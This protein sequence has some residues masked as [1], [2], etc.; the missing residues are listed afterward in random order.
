MKVAAAM[1]P[2]HDTALET[3]AREE[4]G[5]DPGQ[6]GSPWS[7]AISSFIAFTIGALIP[8]LPWFFATGNAEVVASVILG[9]IAAVVVG[10]A[11]AKLTGRSPLWSGARQLAITAGAAAVTFAVGRLVG[12]GVS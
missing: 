2:D 9:A 6:L 11:L 1:M 10:V 5:I 3:H 7:A 4:L 8:L 12:V